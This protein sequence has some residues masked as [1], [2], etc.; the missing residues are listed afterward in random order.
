MW[1]G[2]SGFF[3]R[4]M[5]PCPSP[6]GLKIFQMRQPGKESTRGW[7]V[8]ALEISATAKLSDPESPNCDWISA[9]DSASTLGRRGKRWWFCSAAATNQHKHEISN[10]RRNIGPS[11]RPGKI[12]E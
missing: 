10:K 1:C 2:K 12:Y 3:E 6:S 4:R 7:R 8:R 11:T 9:R 5:E